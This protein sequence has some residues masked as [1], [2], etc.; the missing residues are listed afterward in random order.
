TPLPPPDQPLKLLLTSDHQL[1]PMV[2]ANLE[3]V[4][5]T[6]G[7]LDGILFAG[8]LVNVPDRASEWFDDSRGGAFFPALQGHARVKLNGR[9]YTGAPLIQSAPL[10][11]ALGNH[12]VMGRRVNATEPTPEPSTAPLSG[13]PSLNGQFSDAVP[14]SVALELARAA[15]EPV[16]E[17]HQPDAESWLADRSFNWQTVREIFT[18]PE[19]QAVNP[20]ITRQT[21]AQAHVSQSNTPQ[22]QPNPAQSSLS[23]PQS[24]PHPGYYAVT[25]GNLR[26][27]V[28]Y[29]TT[30]WRPWGLGDQVRGRYRERTEDLDH[31][32]RWGYGQ[33]I[34]E[35]IDLDSAQ[36]QWLQQE[37]A[38]PEFQTAAYKVVM[39]HHPVHTLGDNI[40]PAYTDPVQVLV[41]DSDGILTAVRYEY[42]LDRDYLNRDLAPLLEAAGV[43]LVLNGHSHLWNRFTSPK[44][45]H[46]LETSNVGNSYG[47]FWAGTDTI[48]ATLPR[49]VPES[50]R[51]IYTSHGDPWGLEPILPTIA[52]ITDDRGNALPYIASNEITVFSILDTG[53]G[54]VS[55]YAFDTRQPQSEVTLFDRFYLGQGTGSAGQ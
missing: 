50:H 41:R 33:H 23:P 24:S 20:D 16:P 37:L 2:A 8:D 25:L 10:F 51:E 53:D 5:A 21:L 15:G 13:P 47:A 18:W 44:G 40:V 38:S 28:L 39:F 6:V 17:P 22:P 1:K 34:F 52:P 48:A 29:A 32:E 19:N 27:V 9:M 46:F 12:E 45:L 11:P 49:P 14:R 31:P 4:A 54:S 43:D 26:L 3:Q 36:Y 35:P 55:S 7:Q 30:I 42:P